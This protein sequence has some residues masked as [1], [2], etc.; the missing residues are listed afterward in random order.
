[1]A[2]RLGSARTWKVASAVT[3]QK[4]YHQGYIAVKALMNADKLFQTGLDPN[5]PQALFAVRNLAL[6]NDESTTQ[7]ACRLGVPKG[8]LVETFHAQRGSPHDPA[9]TLGAFSFSYIVTYATVCFTFYFAI[10]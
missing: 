1:M 8:A 2:T 5:R 3:V 7:A 9:A 10:F 6:L 4:I